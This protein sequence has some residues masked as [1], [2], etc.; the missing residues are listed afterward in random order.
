MGI[1]ISKF[2]NRGNCLFV[3][4]I[5]TFLTSSHGN[6][7]PYFRQMWDLSHENVRNMG[8]VV[9]KM[10]VVGIVVT[11]VESDRTWKNF[12]LR[13]A[14]ARCRYR[15]SLWNLFQWSLCCNVVLN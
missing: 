7:L 9:L 3:V 2:V 1:V 15:F 12:S 11:G 10:D 13:I 8:I 4:G 6:C 5:V 14:F